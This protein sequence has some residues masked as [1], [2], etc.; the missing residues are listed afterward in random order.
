MDKEMNHFINDNMVMEAQI[1]TEICTW[2]VKRAKET[3]TTVSQ[4]HHN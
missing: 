1:T 4:E 3:T 2:V